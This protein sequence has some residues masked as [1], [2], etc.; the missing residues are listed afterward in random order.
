M[1]LQNEILA[2]LLKLK[3]KT[4]SPIEKAKIKKQLKDLYKKIKPKTKKNVKFY[5][6]YKEEVKDILNP[7]K[8][9]ILTEKEKAKQ[10]K[11]KNKKDIEKLEVQLQHAVSQG[12]QQQI[13]KIQEEIQDKEIE[14][15]F[16][17]EAEKKH[18]PIESAKYYS[19]L[20]KNIKSEQDVA[21]YAQIIYDKYRR[22]YNEAEARQQTKRQLTKAQKKLNLGEKPKVFKDKIQKY[23]EHAIF[24]VQNQGSESEELEQKEEQPL[25]ILENPKVVADRMKQLDF[26]TV[27][28]EINMYMNQ[29]RKGDRYAQEIIEDYISDFGAVEA[30][31]SEELKNFAAGHGRRK[32][33]I[34]GGAGLADYGMVLG[35]LPGIPQFLN[36]LGP[37]GQIL[38]QAGGLAQSFGKTA[39]QLLKQQSDSGEKIDKF[40]GSLSP[41]KSIFGFGKKKKLNMADLQG[42]AFLSDLFGTIG[43]L[44]PKASGILGKIPEYGDIAQ[45]GNSFLGSYSRVGEDIAKMLGLGNMDHTLA[46]YGNMDL[47]GKTK[48]FGKKGGRKMLSLE[49]PMYKH[50]LK[51]GNKINGRNVSEEYEEQYLNALKHHNLEKQQQQLH[52]ERMLENEIL[53]QQNVDQQNALIQLQYY[54]LLNKAQQH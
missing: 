48:G 52:A 32:R 25:V 11:N 37:F 18:E 20:F 47:F 31:P 42:G 7:L 13:E 35:S 14:I 17:K 22:Q 4:L 15:E 27:E 28:P 50:T 5:N 39:G 9:K 49:H 36:N 44:T 10:L 12:N 34:R 23:L 24:S 40:S 8:E 21:N 38:G 45:I 41:L 43:G 46:G 54:D 16:V 3:D 2:L 51:G 26:L 30:L 53:N 33:K 6:L 1:S 19:N 29:A